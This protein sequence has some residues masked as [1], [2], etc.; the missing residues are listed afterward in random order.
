[1]WQEQRIVPKFS[2]HTTQYA[3]QRPAVLGSGFGEQVVKDYNG[4]TYWLSA[5][6]RSFMPNSKLPKWFNVALGYGAEGMLTATS[7]SDAG[8][9]LPDYERYRQ[10][11]LSLDVDLTKIETKS[12]LLRTL[13]S[14]FNTIKIPAPTFEIRGSQGVKFHWIYF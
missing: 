14:L 7:S 3:R 6:L 11:Y 13:F 2:F 12:S 9:V 5:N 8:L 10:F 1:M 4:Q